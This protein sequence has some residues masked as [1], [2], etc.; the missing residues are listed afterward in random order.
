M[1][2]LHDA[3]A[4]AKKE[5]G[6]AAD[7]KTDLL[8]LPKPQSFLEELFGSQSLGTTLT[9]STLDQLPKEW[10]GYLAEATVLAYLFKYPINTMLPYRI[11]I[12]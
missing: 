3:V 12:D 6:I 9:A 8:L 1:G 10:S 5:C 4:D 7:E 2:G 11:T